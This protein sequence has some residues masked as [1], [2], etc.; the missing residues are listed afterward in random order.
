MKDDENICDKC[1][2]HAK[3]LYG[4][5]EL[6]VKLAYYCS[7]CYKKLY[8]EDPETWVIPKEFDLEE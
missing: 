1:K 3:T 4:K 2:N 8:K 7:K 5:T 6:D